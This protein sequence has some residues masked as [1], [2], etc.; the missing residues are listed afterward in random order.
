M[1]IFNARH[2]AE[3]LASLRDVSQHHSKLVSVGTEP[4]MMSS[5]EAQLRASERDP[6]F[7]NHTLELQKRM[8]P[9]VLRNRIPISGAP[10]LRT[11]PKPYMDIL[12]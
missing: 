1:L 3:L 11:T 10:S 7:K 8:D 9:K 5:S 4:L 12:S 6:K 2:N